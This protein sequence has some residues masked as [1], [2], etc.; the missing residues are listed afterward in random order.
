MRQ[1]R[2]SPSNRVI[3]P[4]NRFNLTFVYDL[5]SYTGTCAD[6]ILPYR[7]F[8]VDRVQEDLQQDDKLL[9]LAEKNLYYRR[10]ILLERSHEQEQS[11]V[12]RLT[13]GQNQQYYEQSKLPD[14]L[15][16]MLKDQAFVCVALGDLLE[17][18][19]M[20]VQAR[21]Y[22]QKDASGTWQVVEMIAIHELFTSTETG[23]QTQSLSQVFQ[24]L[25]PQVQQES[26]DHL[27]DL[28][29][30]IGAQLDFFIPNLGS[31][32][33]DL[34]FDPNGKPHLISMGG[35]EQNKYL[36]RDSSR[37]SWETLIKCM[38]GYC[39][40]LLAQADQEEDRSDGL[41]PHQALRIV[42]NKFKR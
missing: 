40:K 8:R 12:Y 38:V 30:R 6:S 27:R 21:V 39:C 16:F 15:S 29:L 11:D 4:I 35:F 31:L 32:T 22:V 17:Q 42:K 9:V 13:I 7:P 19:G 24:E 36:L 10:A 1:I 2:V 23:A 25:I 33:L 26:L 18:N 5:L 41:D 34:F 14:V 3:N 28:S 20:P 37:G